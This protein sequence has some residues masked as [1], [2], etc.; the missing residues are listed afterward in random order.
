MRNTQYKVASVAH[1]ASIRKCD[2][3]NCK[4]ET[5]QGIKINDKYFCRN[6][7]YQKWHA[8]QYDTMKR[9]IIMP[10]LSND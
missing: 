2:G 4:V 1:G 9:S 3:P 6:L 10:C 5:S 8:E 7:C